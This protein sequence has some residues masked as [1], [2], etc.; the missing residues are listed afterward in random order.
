MGRED[1][2]GLRRR[3][4]A[5]SKTGHGCSLRTSSTRLIKYQNENSGG[6]RSCTPTTIPRMNH[7]RQVS[8]STSTSVGGRNRAQVISYKVIRYIS[9]FME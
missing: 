6:I 5:A 9:I 1:Q 4:Q 7:G 3:G 2:D 8:A